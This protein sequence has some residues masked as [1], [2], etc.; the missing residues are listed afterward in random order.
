VIA[1]S[2]VI[3]LAGCTS[4]A[5]RESLAV[6]PAPTATADQTYA[7]F[8]TGVPGAD[9]Q[10]NSAG[11][12]NDPVSREDMVIVDAPPSVTW[13]AEYENFSDG[14]GLD[15]PYLVATGYELPLAEVSFSDTARLSPAQIGG[16]PATW[17]VDP[18]DPEATAV[19]A[20]SMSPVRTVS[21]EGYNVSTAQLGTYAASL[22]PA[23]ES[24]WISAHRTML[25]P[26]D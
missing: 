10:I 4:S 21:L 3:A 11:R 6:S 2:C 23:T 12:N 15:E 22:K 14:D 8:P 1:I 19:L 24:E 25:A 7:I 20:I 5:D 9:W 17:V 16:R 18:R 13:T 26:I